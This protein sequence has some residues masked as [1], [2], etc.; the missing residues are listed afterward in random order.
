MEYMFIYIYIYIGSYLLA[1]AIKARMEQ[2]YVFN[3]IN[4]NLMNL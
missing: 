4:I 1:L 2:K 3:A